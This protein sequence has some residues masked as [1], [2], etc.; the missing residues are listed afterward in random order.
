MDLVMRNSDIRS[1]T[2]FSQQLQ[3]QTPGS[4]LSSSFTVDG[5]LQTASFITEMY[6]K[7][8][9]FGP[10]HLYT[11]TS[12][13]NSVKYASLAAHTP[14][15]YNGFARARYSFTPTQQQ[16]TLDEVVSEI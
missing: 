12:G 1:V 16:H 10:Q 2:D 6:N 5:R 8:E 13:S 9:A 4:T 15:Y 7:P 11:L 3:L 14:P